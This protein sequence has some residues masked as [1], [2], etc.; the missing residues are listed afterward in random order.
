MK[1]NP[2]DITAEKNLET[3]L[4]NSNKIKIQNTLMIL[5]GFLFI[6]CFGLL[7]LVLPQEDFSYDENRLLQTFP[8]I[9]I[10][11]I[12]NGSF[13]SELS[14]FYSDQF[15]MRENFVELKTICELS[16]LKIENNKV[17]FASD[18]YLIKKTE[19]SDYSKLEEN[20]QAIKEFESKTDI[21]VTSVILPRTIDVEKDN[22]IPFF[23]YFHTDKIWGK[24][25]A[26]EANIMLLNDY[27]SA[28]DDEY[29]YYKTDHH[30]TT[31][32]AYYTYTALA[33]SLG[34]TPKPLSFFERQTFSSN[35]LGTTYSSSP[36][37]SIEADTIELFRYESDT[38]YTLEI[39][40]TSKK[41]N[42]F[43]DMD[44]I[45]VKDKYS[46]FLYGN[47]GHI[48][49]YP[50]DETLRSQRETLLIIKDSYANAISPFLALHYNLEIIDLRY[51]DYSYDIINEVN[52]D[53]I[54]I[55]YGA[56]SVATSDNLSMV[57]RLLK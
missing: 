20:L 7:T 39:V 23:N 41:Y 44:A 47:N 48:S 8:T 34:Y 31:L 55:L 56:D 37:S 26:S 29:I 15:P 5:T 45:D 35:F 40:D 1:K 52:P 3:Q 53:R 21:P 28:L 46:V 42:G 11:K 33:T 2:A 38:N 50:T 4:K 43:Y 9:S 14:K 17:I 18:G 25:N 12:V 19:Y 32:G 24:I 22:N 16:T 51:Y 10:D 54:L 30:Q 36:M 27:F 6:F 57:L 49:I 13:E